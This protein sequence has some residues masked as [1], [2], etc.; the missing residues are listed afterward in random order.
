MKIWYLV[1]VVFLLFQ[2]QKENLQYETLAIA[3]TTEA[4]SNLQQKLMSQMKEGGTEQAIPFCH[5]NAL[6]FTEN[7]GNQ[8]AVSLR[9]ITDKPRN[10]K[11]MMT[12]DELKI[13]SL[14]KQGKSKEGVYPN[15]IVRSDEVVTV[16]VPIVI[17]GQCVGCHGKA[18]EITKDTKETLAKLFPND[19]A[20][21][22]EIGDLRGLFSVTFKK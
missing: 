6:R 3:I 16:Y 22:Y 7:L 11:N 19:R 14:V 5:E 4:K 2:C 13:F 17:T 15:Q 9:R 12:E 21:D 20:I 10:P 1:P 18:N 8:K